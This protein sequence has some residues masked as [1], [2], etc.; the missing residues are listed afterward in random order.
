MNK[1]EADHHLFN[2]I[3]QVIGAAHT[4]RPSLAMRHFLTRDSKGYHSSQNYE[5]SYFYKGNKETI[6]R[7]N[8]VLCLKRDPA[9]ERLADHWVEPELAVFLGNNHEI[10]AFTLANDLT[11]ISI[12]SQGRTEKTDSTYIAKFWE[13]SGSLGPHF[14]TSNQL[15]NIGSL[16][17]ELEIFR[18]ESLLY[19]Q[20]YLASR[21]LYQLSDIPDMVANLYVE[22]FKK[23]RIPSKQIIVDAKNKLPYGTII[24]TGTGIIIPKKYYSQPGDKV[25]IS[26]RQIGKLT[27]FV[28]K[29]Q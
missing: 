19:R 14:V 21:R 22:K 17:I 7:D 5:F 16:S 15:R 8:E 20:S 18:E 25:I 13:R 3:V 24:M 10:I 23:S 4:Y 6:A 1:P 9:T 28:C 29:G 27:N 2:Q 26:S 12:E 11:A